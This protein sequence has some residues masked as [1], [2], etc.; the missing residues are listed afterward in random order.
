MT[1]SLEEV[2]TRYWDNFGDCGKAGVKV[3]SASV[4]NYGTRFE[5]TVYFS[6]AT[7]SWDTTR[8]WRV[9]LV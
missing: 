1:S 7:D 2:P 6:F 5:G 9:V 4:T 3:L 8:P